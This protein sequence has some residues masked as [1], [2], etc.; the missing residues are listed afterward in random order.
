MQTQ[1]TAMAT[2][3]TSTTFSIPGMDCPSEERLIRLA[4]AE[5][6][7]HVIR[8]QFDIAERSLVVVH[9]CETEAL[10]EKL[11]P[12]NFGAV[13]AS[14]ESAAA[15]TTASASAPGEATMLRQLLLINA[16]MF[17]AELVFGIYAES[18]GLIADSIDMLADAMVY[19]LALLAVG[20]PV[21]HQKKTAKASGLLQ[22]A[23][24]VGVVV[25]VVRR[26]VNGSAPVEAYMMGVAA[27][28][29][30]ANLACI[31]LLARHKD[32]GLHLKASWIFTTNDA[33]ANVGVIV[34]GALVWATSSATPDLAVGAMVSVVVMAG[35]IRILRL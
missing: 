34:A 31:A 24:A 14:S 33:I 18:T 8:L 29:L 4:L 3:P 23:L 13:V 6:D 20:K 12:L 32:G 7:D 15:D 27:I 16:A 21:A 10:L 9:T 11:A 30:V 22:L 28:A 25:D 1:E 35:A 26:A 19:S 17:V 2:T 5:L